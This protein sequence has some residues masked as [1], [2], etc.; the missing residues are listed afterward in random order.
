[1]ILKFNTKVKRLVNF[2]YYDIMIII[3]QISIFEKC[4]KFQ[5]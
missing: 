1:M 2:K 3:N 4:V 5:I